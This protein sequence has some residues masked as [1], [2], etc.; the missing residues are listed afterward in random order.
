[1][2]HHQLIRSHRLT[3]THCHHCFKVMTLIVTVTLTIDL[4][5]AISVTLTHNL[6]NPLLSFEVMTFVGTVTLT[7]TLTQCH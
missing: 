7:V 6:K 3:L 5:L 1:M 4:Y 2:E